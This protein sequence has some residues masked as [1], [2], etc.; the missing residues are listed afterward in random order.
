MKENIDYNTPIACLTF[1][2]FLEAFR[3]AQNEPIPPQK[4]LPK[5]LTVPQLAELTGYSISTINIKNCKKEIPGSKKLNGRVLFDT[6]IILDWIE[7]GSVRTK[8]ERLQDLE[9]RFSKRGGK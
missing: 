2:Q 5:F 8:D 9:N 3:S 6:S 4:E 7:S 1:G